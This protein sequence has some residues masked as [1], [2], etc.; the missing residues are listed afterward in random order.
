M[1]FGAFEFS[2]FNFWSKKKGCQSARLV[3]FDHVHCSCHVAHQFVQ[4]AGQAE[5]NKRV[6]HI[7]L[8]CFRFLCKLFSRFCNYIN[9]KKFLISKF[10]DDQ[11]IWLASERMN[12]DRMWLVEIKLWDF[13]GLL[14]CFPIFSISFSCQTY[15]L[16]KIS[17]F[18]ND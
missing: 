8:F 6:W 15:N 3:V 7:F 14:K 11:M 4:K 12:E 17:L 1:A 5:Q 16:E 9:Q 2:K 13:S 10:F 18:K